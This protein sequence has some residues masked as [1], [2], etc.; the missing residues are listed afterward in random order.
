MVP[1]VPQHDDPL[2][3][4]QPSGISDAFRSIVLLRDGQN[5]L[6]P[7]DLVMNAAEQLVH[8]LLPAQVIVEDR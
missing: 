6:A 5:H 8:A 2:R 7:Y 3:L 4:E 1:L